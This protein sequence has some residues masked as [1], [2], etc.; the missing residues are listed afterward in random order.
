[1]TFRERANPAD[2]DNIATAGV[3]A[4][5]TLTRTA[6]PSGHHWELCG[7][8][9]SYSIPGEIAGRL[10]IEDGGETVFDIDITNGGAGGFPIDPPIEFDP[11]AALVAT[12]V[13]VA[14]AV[15]KLNLN[16]RRSDAA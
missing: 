10:H 9:W 4:S 16:L 5:V 14:T 11:T 15:G 8:Y 12:L 6:P 2:G 13:G 3:G 1:M 7:V